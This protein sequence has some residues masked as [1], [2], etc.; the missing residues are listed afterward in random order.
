M[1]RVRRSLSGGVSGGTAPMLGQTF[2]QA[3][4][5]VFG[6]A[7]ATSNEDAGSPK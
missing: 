5:V 3:Y 2:L 1:F 4:V 7:L 6:K